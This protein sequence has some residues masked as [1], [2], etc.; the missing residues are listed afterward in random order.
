MT[1]S[2]PTVRWVSIEMTFERSVT[3]ASGKMLAM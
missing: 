2:I 1:L 3:F